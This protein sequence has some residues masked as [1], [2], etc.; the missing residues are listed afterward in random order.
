MD[1][2]TFLHNLHFDTDK[3]S[4]PGWEVDWEDAPLPYKLYQGLPVFPLSHEVPL[5]LEQREPP[6][7]PSLRKVSS[8]LY[9]V[10]GLTQLSQTALSSGEEGPDLM[11]SFRRFVPSGGALYPNELYVYLKTEDFPAG[12]YHYDAARH[13][14]VLLREGNYDSYIALALGGRCDVSSCFATVFVSTMFWKNFYKYNNFSYRLQGLDAGA[15]VGQLLEVSK[16]QGFSSGVYFQFLDRAVNHL[17]GVDDSEESVYAVVPL[18]VKPTRW[19]SGNGQEISAQDLCGQMPEIQTP[20][21]IRS[22]VVKP[23]PMLIRMNQA[24]MWESTQLFRCLAKSRSGREEKK[25]RIPLLRANRLSC[26]LASVCKNRFSPDLDFVLGKVSQKQL[27][28]ML[29]ETLSSFTYRND[30]DDPYG[31]PSQRISLFGCLTNVKGIA[32][33]LYCYDADEH[34]LQLIEPG[35]HRLSLQYSMKAA[36]VNLFQVPLCFH[37]GGDRDHFLSQLGYRGYRIQQMETGILMQKLL[38]AGAAQ[39]LGGHP[40]LGYDVS[41]CDN[42]YRLSPQGKTSLIKIPIGPTRPRPWLKAGLH[43]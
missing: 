22:K 19:I 16:A 6:E 42:L 41:T 14:L 25:Q 33:G 18:S 2:E 30:L 32:D 35:D 12:V 27:A 11:Q 10:F 5:T 26:D 23:F 1:L 43:S 4:P 7:Q 40:L 28:A 37:I 29:Q 38:L 31:K 17:L 36:N 24:S 39:G 21:Y 8:F 3:A 9:Y 15:L 34:A 20:H 13:S